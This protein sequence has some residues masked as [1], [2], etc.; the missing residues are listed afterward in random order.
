M[1]SN[2]DPTKPSS[3]NAY[4]EDVRANF[5]FAKAEIEA[6]QSHAASTTN[7]HS[8]T[9]TQVGADPAGTASA[10]I[11]IHESESDPH[12][13][14]FSATT[15]G[16]IAALTLVTVDAEDHILIEDASDANSKKRI[17]AS[18]LLSGAGDVTGPAG[19]T[20][21]N[22]AAFDGTTGKLIKDSVYSPASF[23]PAAHVGTGGTEHADATTTAAGFMS[24]S[25]KT[26]LDG[27][28][29][30]AEVNNISDVNATDLTDAGDS[31]LHYHSTDRDRANHTG[32]Q[33]LATISDAG[34]SA[35]LNVGTTAGTVAAGDDARFAVS[36][37]TA[38]AGEDLGGHRMVV[39][40]SGLAVY[41]SN[42]TTTHTNKVLGMTTGAVLNGAAATIQ[43]HGE[44][45]EPS[46]AWALDQP[47]FLSTTGL[48]T[49]TPPVTGFSQ[50]IGFPTSA[51]SL[52]IKL[53]EPLI[54]T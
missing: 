24:A 54:L 29:A 1:A 28:E 30:G 5:A 53:R 46:W 36:T 17:A 7:P 45:T 37:T 4:T 26:K 23:T 39:I 25:D 47:V 12:P 44:I 10:A 6:L 2:I 21:S 8:V 16:E 35:G 42:T 43:T 15:D 41:A 31:A 32:T 20:D 49:Q 48:I 27:I 38:T 19:A 33:A 22:F 51:T 3:G 40:T 50:I 14:Y 11:A 9:A 13:Q 18:D 34:N 52:F